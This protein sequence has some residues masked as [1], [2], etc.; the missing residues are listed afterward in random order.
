M[1]QYS[2][3]CAGPWWI[4]CSRSAA[5]CWQT[6]LRW[7]PSAS[8]VLTGVQVETAIP[9]LSSS[10][11]PKHLREWN[12]PRTIV[13]HLHFSFV[14]LVLWSWLILLP[15]HFTSTVWSPVLWMKPD[16]CNLV[17]RCSD[18][19]HWNKTK[20]SIRTLSSVSKSSVQ[21]YG[22]LKTRQRVK[23]WKYN[24]NLSSCV[25]DLLELCKVK[26]TQISVLFHVT[27][28]SL[29]SFYCPGRCKPNLIIYFQHLSH[30]D[31]FEEHVYG[32]RLCWSPQHVRLTAVQEPCS[33]QMCSTLHSH[34]ST[35]HNWSQ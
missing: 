20:F 7:F 35:S 21:S 18:N 1:R 34:L 25:G 8:A 10:V 19:V 5:K 3:R 29:P 26:Y 6:C 2:S 4:H 24:A 16:S 30:E 23:F 14:R 13:A 9:D 32:S 17:K 11:I 33:N 12:F 15:P 28:L 27:T 31:N 22:L